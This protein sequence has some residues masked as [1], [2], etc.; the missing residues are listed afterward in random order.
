MPVYETLSE[1]L[2]DLRSRGFTIDLNLA[3][4]KLKCHETGVCLSPDEFDVV[5]YYR[6][7]GETNPSDQEIVFAISSKDSTTKGTLVSSYGVYRED[8]TEELIQKLSMHEQ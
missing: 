6:F 2:D 7:E 3:F 8:A 5:E 1:A 4:D